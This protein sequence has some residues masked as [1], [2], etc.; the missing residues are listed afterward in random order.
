MVNYR[1]YM[2]R[3]PQSVEIEGVHALRETEKGLLCNVHNSDYWVP[4]SQI[5]DVSQVQVTGDSGTLCINRW[6]VE[7]NCLEHLLEPFQPNAGESIILCSTNKVYR[8]LAFKYHPDRSPEKAEF[9]KD[10]N[11][12]WQALQSDLKNTR[13]VPRQSGE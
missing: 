13:S 9:M 1:S 12:L 8:R 10:L 4:K 11:E 3:R 7:K 2:K 5:S 6:W